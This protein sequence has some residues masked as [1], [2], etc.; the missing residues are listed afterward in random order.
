[1]AA[2]K[3][4]MR[5]GILPGPRTHN[6]KNPAGAYDSR[7]ALNPFVRGILRRLAA[8]QAGDSPCAQ[9]LDLLRENLD[10][11]EFAR[12]IGYLEAF[13]GPELQE[14][15]ATESDVTRNYPPGEDEEE[16]AREREWEDARAAVRRS[17]PG[18]GGGEDRRRSSRR[19][20]RHAMDQALSSN[21]AGYGDRF[22]DAKRI[23]VM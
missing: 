10:Q 14:A 19:G 3:E 17:N 20:T 23:K 13:A 5:L 16:P 21:R 11:S 12:A 2:F 6:A 9:L 18:Q 1:L 8:D 7:V 4:A 15:G 22:P